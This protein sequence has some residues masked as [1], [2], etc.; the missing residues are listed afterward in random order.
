MVASGILML[1]LAGAMSFFIYQS[2]KGTDATKIKSA[3]DNLT[4][5]LVMIQRD[6]M[7]AGYGV[8][9]GPAGGSKDPKTFAVVT[10][11][12]YGVDQVTGDQYSST[13]TTSRPDKLHVGYGTF[14]DMNF[15]VNG[16]ND[17]NTVFKNLAIK[18][19]GSSGTTTFHYDLFPVEM[20]VTTDTKPVGGFIC[21][22]CP[23]SASLPDA[24][25][26]D[27]KNTGSRPAGTKDWT[28]K[29][30]SGSSNLS[31]NVVPSIVYRIAK[32]SKRPTQELQRNGV[33]IA[34]GDPGIEVYKIEVGVLLYP[35]NY[36]DDPTKKNHVVR[37]TL[38]KDPTT[39]LL[40]V[41][42][43]DPNLPGHPIT[44]EPA[45]RRL[46]V[47]IDY[48]VKLSGSNDETTLHGTAKK[49]W[50]KG[51]VTLRADPRVI[52]LGGG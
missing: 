49:T 1:A 4:L 5:A 8:M 20:A 17:S 22:A 18:D 27:W 15:D 31:G 44:T 2:H 29:L 10:K 12:D 32:D 11:T 23:T 48:L 42:Y 37:G 26:V 40:Y 34:G 52:V 41:R 38:T 6:I 24:A 35:S 13:D 45:N 39:K 16:T 50:Y 7:A 51:F 3:R 33:R 36:A 28:V 21:G 9:A 47:R 25:D 43:P 30:T 46:A 19:L 14:L